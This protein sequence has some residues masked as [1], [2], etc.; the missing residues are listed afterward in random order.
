[1][2]L[3]TRVNPAIKAQLRQ[4]GVAADVQHVKFFADLD[5]ALEFCE[6]GVLADDE[7]SRVHNANSIWDRIARALPAGTPMTDFMTYLVPRTY[8]A[9]EFLLTQ[10]APPAEII[11]IESGRVTVRL[12]FP[13]G[14][15]I[16]LLS[17][18]VGTIMG[19]VGVYLNHPRTASAVADLRTRAFILTVDKLREMERNHPAQ[20]NALHFTMVGLLSERLT[21]NN[22]LLQRLVN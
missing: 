1:M 12:S 9:G 10:G 2:L 19:E 17:M 22:G 6:E 20:A 5:Y 4:A 13:D 11:F 3:F 15:S 21:N 16:R 8:E 18:T 14:R 7:S